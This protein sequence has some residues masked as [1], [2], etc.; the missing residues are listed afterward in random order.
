MRVGGWKGEAP[1]ERVADEFDEDCRPR[2]PVGARPL[3]LRVVADEHLSPSSVNGGNSAQATVT[4]SDPAPA[5]GATVTLA[6]SNTSAASVPSSVSVPA[7]ASSATFVV[8]TRP[9]AAT[10][11]VTISASYAGTARDA[12]LTV[13]PAPSQETVTIQR[14]E[15]TAS[16][17]QL[18]VSATSTAS[19]ATLSVYVTANGEFI[20]TLRSKGGG[21]QASWPTNPRNIT[22]RSSLGGS[23][24]KDVALK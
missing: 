20:G 11:S 22:V 6:S 16:K 9:V 14:A 10:A 12:A 1:L 17:K 8:T 18:R 21:D 2:Q 7:G 3:P 13:S 5:G 24:T 15:Y 23:A 19:N 4:L